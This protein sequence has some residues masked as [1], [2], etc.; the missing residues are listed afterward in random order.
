MEVSAFWDDVKRFGGLSRQRGA[1]RAAAA[2]LAALGE[3]LFEDEARLLARELTPKL[4]RML[5]RG[6]HARE[7]RLEDFYE[8]VGVFEKVDQGF[9]R[10]HAQAVC[11]ALAIHLSESAVTRLRRELPALASLFTPRPGESHV[12]EPPTHPLKASEP[13]VAYG[14]PGR[15]HPIA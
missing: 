6:V 4:A 3:G 11:E 8:R 5:H 1:E 12:G 13:T 2:T 10:E 15:R 14:C 9:A 7:L